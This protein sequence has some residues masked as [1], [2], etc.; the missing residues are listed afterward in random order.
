MCSPRRLK[1]G[2]CP[3][4]QGLETDRRAHKRALCIRDSVVLSVSRGSRQLRVTTQWKERHT[5]RGQGDHRQT[6]QVWV[7]T[8]RLLQEGPYPN[9]G[10]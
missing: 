6:Q 5:D 8:R 10:L 2:I 3:E 4:A 9:E 7:T 1:D